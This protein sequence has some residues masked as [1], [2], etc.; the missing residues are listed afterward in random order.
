VEV[1]V[2][3]LTGKTRDSIVHEVL[4]VA[5]L[6]GLEPCPGQIGFEFEEHHRSVLKGK[7]VRVVAKPVAGRDDLY[8]LSLQHDG[9]RLWT[10]AWKVN[11]DHEVLRA[12][13]KLVF[14]ISPKSSSK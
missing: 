2:G 8:F 1:S 7:H 11:T 5:K 13:H 3:E 10:N 9:E 14:M 4:E 6:A 12:N